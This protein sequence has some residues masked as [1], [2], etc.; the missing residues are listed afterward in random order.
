MISYWNV[1]PEVPKGTGSEASNE[2]QVGVELTK[3]SSSSLEDFQSVSQLTLR[4]W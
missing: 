2:T 4:P 3:H 1:N